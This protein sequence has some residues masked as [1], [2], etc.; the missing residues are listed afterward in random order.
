MDAPTTADDSAQRL[1]DWVVSQRAETIRDR[2]PWTA[3]ALRGSVVRAGALAPLA[4]LV[5]LPRSGQQALY[6]IGLCAGVV[7]AMTFVERW[8]TRDG[9]PGRWG[10]AAG[11]GALWAIATAGLLLFGLMLRVN[12]GGV[13]W[14][15]DPTVAL[16]Q[17]LGASS[18]IPIQMLVPLAV[19]TAPLAPMAWGYFRA[20]DA[21]EAIEPSLIATFP[22][23]TVAMLLFLGASLLAGQDA[24][25]SGGAA[26]TALVVSWVYLICSTS[27]ALLGFGTLVWLEGLVFRGRPQRWGRDLRVPSRLGRQGSGSAGPEAHGGGPWGPP[28]EAT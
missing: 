4:A 25:L 21:V 14:N 23:A 18:E 3:R 12:F 13:A 8:L 17:L 16:E 20:R 15:A 9:L 1:H 26:V 11:A 7:A 6:S 24:A 28:K 2:E 22:A 19:L 27:I 10:A 5:S